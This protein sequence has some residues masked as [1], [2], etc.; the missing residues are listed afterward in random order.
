VDPQSVPGRETAHPKCLPLIPTM[1]LA[2]T[3][4]TQGT[5]LNRMQG[6]IHALSDLG[7]LQ[8]IVEELRA[9]GYKVDSALLVFYVSKLP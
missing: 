2:V 3:G 9:S 8:G 7:E 4:M 6:P 5:R 1:L